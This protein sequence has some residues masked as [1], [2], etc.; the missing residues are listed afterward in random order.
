MSNNQRFCFTEGLLFDVGHHAEKLREQKTV[1]ENHEVIF[2]RAEGQF[3][4]L[5]VV[6]VIPKDVSLRPSIALYHI[7]FCSA[8]FCLL[9]GADINYPAWLVVRVR[10]LRARAC[11]CV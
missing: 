2:R 1:M 7:L 9:F 6:K 4:N 5:H 10:V 8:L 11:L 3:Q